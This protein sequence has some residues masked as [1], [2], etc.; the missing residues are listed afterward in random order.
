MNLSLLLSDIS[1]TDLDNA[2]LTAGKLVISSTVNVTLYYKI[3]KNL[4]GSGES[5]FERD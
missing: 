5:E 4:H 1:Q 3:L 2:V